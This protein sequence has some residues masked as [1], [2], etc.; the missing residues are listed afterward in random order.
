MGIA[1]ALTAL[2]C[3]FWVNHYLIVVLVDIHVLIT[4]FVPKGFAPALM[5][6]PL[7]LLRITPNIAALAATSVYQIKFVSD[8]LVYVKM[9][10][11]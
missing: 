1:L 4:K 10:L 2:V 6:L 3:H 5:E 8:C 7:L 11:L 9:A